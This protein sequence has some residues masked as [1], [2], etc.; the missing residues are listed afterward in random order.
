MTFEPVRSGWQA[1]QAGVAMSVVPR[2]TA[3][4]PTE[5]FVTAVPPCVSTGGEAR[6]LVRL[7]WQNVQVV[8]HEAKPAVVWHAV[9]DRAVPPTPSRLAPWQLLQEVRPPRF[10][11]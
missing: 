2:C 6:P 9:Q 1:V 8:A 11:A 10:A 4:A 5:T 3:W 7:P